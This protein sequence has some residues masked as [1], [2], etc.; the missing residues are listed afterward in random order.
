M[1]QVPLG[2]SGISVSV[3]GLG[4]GGPSRLGLKTGNSQ[5]Q[6]V[7]LVR[8]AIDLGINLIDTA[9]AYK[10]ETIVAQ[11]IRDVP[12]ERIVLATKTGEHR[13]GQLRS[14][15]DV[16]QSLEASL[17]RLGVETIDL[18][19]MH[20]VRPE[21]YR[22]VA[23]NIYPHLDKARRAGKIRLL[24]VTEG[25]VPDP[26]HRM[27]RMAVADELWDAVMV[28]FNLLNP[29][30]RKT[31]LPTAQDKGIA[32]LD[33]FAVRRAL[34]QPAKLRELIDHLVRKPS[35]Q[36]DL[37][38][39][40][41]D[42]L[43]FLT[44]PGVAD[45]IPAAAYRFCRHEPGID[46]VLIGTGNVEHLRANVEAIQAGPLPDEVLERLE[47]LFGQVDSVSGN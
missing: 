22:H 18:Y 32:T 9:E 21:H 16:I 11:A 6:A 14:G 46:V 4:A 25:F 39:D 43:G 30:A 13:D 47:A 1:E 7:G 29:S 34:S 2:S 35:V 12:R 10:T 15:P 20:G 44:H 33:M 17:S 8:E 36:P 27:L 42:P 5:A 26:D 41:A 38:D 37:L 24:G 23:E 28:G 19:Q 3:A 31:I 45:S 40:P